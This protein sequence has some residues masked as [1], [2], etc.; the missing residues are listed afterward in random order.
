MNLILGGKSPITEYDDN[1]TYKSFKLYKDIQSRLNLKYWDS[2]W[3]E[4]S[5]AYDIYDNND[6]IVKEYGGF[7]PYSLEKGFNWR[8]KQMNNSDSRYLHWLLLGPLAPYQYSDS[9]VTSEAA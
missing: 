3:V 1:Y 2:D 6:K 9:D 5:S 8:W 7:Y 4:D